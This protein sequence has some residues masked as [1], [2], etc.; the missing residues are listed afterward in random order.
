MYTFKN[1][2]I[3]SLMALMVVGFVGCEDGNEIF[4]QIQA[5]VQRGAVLRTVDY[6]DAAQEIP[7]GSSDYNFEVTLEEQD[8]QGGDLLAS[9]DVF[10]GFRDNTVEPGAEDLDKAEVLFSNIPASA[11]SA[12]EFGLPRTTF[13]ATLSELL[14]AVGLQEDDIFQTGGDQFTIRFELVL[15]DGRRF[16]NDDNS[17]TITGSFFS[18]PFLYVPVV[19]C[20]PQAPTPGTWMIE[21]QDSFGDGWNGAS[22]DITVDGET[23]SFL[24]DDGSS[25]SETLEIADGASSIGITFNSGDWDSEITFQVISANGNTILDLGPE[26]EAGVELLDYCNQNLGL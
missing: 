14:A 25:A 1:K 13:S 19:V 7:I 11:F 16:S 4:D 17:G 8:Q 2:I 23:T 6:P 3:G 9:V 12:G 26:P 20:P 18:S 5:N 22:L 21:M 15:T 24:I 10:V